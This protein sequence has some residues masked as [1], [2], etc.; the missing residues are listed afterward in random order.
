MALHTMTL[1]TAQLAETVQLLAAGIAVRERELA[2]FD[3][4]AE[5]RES[6]W[7]L[8]QAFGSALACEERS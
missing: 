5:A 8:L 1:S 2:A 7:R 4:L 6:H 3:A